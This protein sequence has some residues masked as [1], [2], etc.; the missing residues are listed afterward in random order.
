[1]QAVSVYHLLSVHFASIRRLKDWGAD[2][3]CL[4]TEARRL[5]AD[6]ARISGLP[7]RT[8]EAVTDA[9]TL[10]SGTTTPDP[11][12]QPLLPVGDGRLAVPGSV[13]LSSNWSRNILSLHARVA[14]DS[15]NAN[16]AAF[17]QTMISVLAPELP[18]RFIH[19]T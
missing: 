3:I 6:L 1:L 15:F 9:L 2:Q 7:I 8:V 19:R 16:S 13:I 18:A 14:E 17:E 10:G 11:A 12:L 4:N 5:N